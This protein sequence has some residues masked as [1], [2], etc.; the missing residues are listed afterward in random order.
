MSRTKKQHTERSEL[1]LEKYWRRTRWAFSRS[2]MIS[3]AF[4]HFLAMIPATILVPVLVNNAF[5]MLIIDISLVLFTSGIGTLLFIIVSH[6]TI[7]AYVGSSFAYIGLTIYLI[8]E[9]ATEG[10][11]YTMAYSY[12]G[13]AYIFS[14]VIL[15]LLS[16]LYRIPRIEKVFSTVFPATV[17]GPAISLIGLELA[18]TAVVD[19]GFD[20]EEG[21]VDANSAIVAMITLAVIV[22]FSLIHHKILKNAAIIVGMVVGTVAFF[23]VNREVTIDFSDISWITIPSFHLPLLTVPDNLW[24]L[25]VAVLPASLILFTENIGR[26]TVIDRMVQESNS[27]NDVN[28]NKQKII[29]EALKAAPDREFIDTNSGDAGIFT[30]PL[31][32]KMQ[33]SL[34]AHGLATLAAGCMGSVPNTLY[35]ENIA[36][37]SI[38]KTD[39]K[40]KE[41]DPIVRAL[42]SPCSWI[43][44]V[45]AA[46][47]AILFSFIG[48]LQTLLL[49]IPKPVIGGMELFLFGIISAPGIQLLVEQRVN[50][51]KISNQLLTAAVLISGVSG[52]CIR[53]GVVELKGMTLGFIIGFVLNIIIIT[54]KWIG[55]LSDVK[56]FD[57]VLADC[58]SVLKDDSRLR[59]L[60][61]R[62]TDEKTVNTKKSFCIPGFVHA[63]KGNGCIV[64]TPDGEWISDETIRDDIAHCELVELGLRDAPDEPLIRFRK[65]AN[66]LF[67]DILSKHLESNFKTAYL[68][69]YEAIDE[70]SDWLFINASDY[71]PLRC[72]RALLLHLSKQVSNSDG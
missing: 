58:L 48:V 7:P 65:T 56:T 43:P 70:D 68:N 19:S 35:A 4:E 3:L 51:K 37:M 11:S 14:G 69:D 18:D 49:G 38:H 71:I 36:V 59:V 61:Y 40:R 63:L 52:L 47:I 44:Y 53:I 9:R 13:W 29:D 1:P 67:V 39:A 20:L 41:P 27:S 22:L 5:D 25:F 45:V 66:G 50:Y 28:G 2:G 26:V 6:G 55:N 21:L 24:G 54:L 64:R 34:V 12:V 16:L 17:I 72:V 33:T 62:K 31:V 15:I 46:L 23:I 32:N 60:G 57:E 8:Q 42:I 30:K 10:V